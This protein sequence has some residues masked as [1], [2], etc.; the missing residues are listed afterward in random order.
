M[1][2]AADPMHVDVYCQIMRQFLAPFDER[3][4]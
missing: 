3:Y 2:T 1:E 4:T